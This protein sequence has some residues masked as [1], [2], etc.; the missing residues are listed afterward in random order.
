MSKIFFTADT[1]FD[2]ANIIKY[3]NRPYRNV[4]EMNESIINNWN[5][6]VKPEDTVYHLGDFS[7][8]NPRKFIDRLNGKI[9]FI[10]GSHDKYIEAP[11]LRIIN[12]DGLKDEYGNSRYITLCHYSMRSWDKSH[13]ASWCLFGHH[14]GSLE[15][16]GLSFDVG[17]DC[18]NFFPVSLEQIDKKMSTLK[19]IVDFR[20][21]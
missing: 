10:K 20:K 5:S 3:S 21:T 18:W 8:G 1:H 11:Y 4:N 6:I 19:P 12:P 9:L 17:V 16:Y 15:P 2:H 7:F 14:H 13:Y